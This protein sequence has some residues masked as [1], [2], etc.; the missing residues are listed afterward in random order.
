MGPKRDFDILYINLSFSLCTVCP[1][2][3]S[4]QTSGPRPPKLD[5]E[6]C[7]SKFEK[8]I[9]RKSSEC[10]FRKFFVIFFEFFYENVERSLMECSLNFPA[11]SQIYIHGLVHFP[12]DLCL[13][14]C[15]LFRGDQ[16]KRQNLV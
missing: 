12:V 10:F 2:S 14:L 8:K 16:P 13:P 7:H 3:I 9:H 6:P 1:F 11:N 5:V 15:T 4:S